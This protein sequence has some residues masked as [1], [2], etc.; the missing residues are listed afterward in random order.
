MITLEARFRKN[1]T[2][3]YKELSGTPALIDPYRRTLVRLNPA[4][5]EIWQLL[6]GTRSVLEI[7]G[8]VRDAFEIDEASLRKDV[9]GFLK[10]MLRREMIR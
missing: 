10:E 6:D 4:A 7:I 5:F 3:L 9:I 1:D 8:S 2:I